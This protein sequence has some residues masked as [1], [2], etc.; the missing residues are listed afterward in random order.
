MGHVGPSRMILVI[1]DNDDVA[2]SMA[3]FLRMLGLRVDVARSG[4]AGLEVALA[5][6]PEV[7]ILDLGMPGLDGYAVA[8]RLRATGGF[9]DVLIIAVTG[10]GR[11]GDRMRSAAAGID[12]HLLKPDA[13]EEIAGLLAA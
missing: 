8:V 4:V 3:L 12:H 13:V 9:E 1:D 5:S 7:I 2:D 6:K 10:L 11:E